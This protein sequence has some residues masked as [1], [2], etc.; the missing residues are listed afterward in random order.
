VTPAVITVR[1]ASGAT[2]RARPEV[3]AQ[4][5]AQLDRAARVGVAERRVGDAAQGTAQRG[6]PRVARETTQVGAAGQEVVAGG[7][8]AQHRLGPARRAGGG[9]S[10]TR[11]AAPWRATR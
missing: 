11:V 2:A 3:G 10:A 4:R 8:L 5:V 7:E 6:Q 1:C 9:R